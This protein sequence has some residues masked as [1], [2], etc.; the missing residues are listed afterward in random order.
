REGIP[1]IGK[2]PFEPEITESIV[3]G[4]PAVEYS[5]NCAT[6]ETKKIWKT[7]EEYFK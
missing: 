5:E 3:N 7:I 4:I 1:V 6:K 2:I